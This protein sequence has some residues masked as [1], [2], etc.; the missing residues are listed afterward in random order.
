MV[1]KINLTVTENQLKLVLKKPDTVKLELLRL[2]AMLLPEDELT[3]KEK[4]EREETRKEI[5]RDS[6]ITLEKLIK[7]LG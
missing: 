4:R 5:A 3:D 6:A 2:R 1:N 7:K